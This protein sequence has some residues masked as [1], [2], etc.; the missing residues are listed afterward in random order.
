MRRFIVDTD[1]GSDDVWAVIEAL[2]AVDTVRV[3]A[4]TVVC[5]NFPL[6]L[7]VKNAMLAVEAAETYLPPVFRGRDEPLA[8]GEL[9]VADEVH[10]PDG[11][12]SMHL[13][14]S[15]RPVETGSAEDVI[16]DLVRKYPGEVE[17]V[18]CGPLTNLAAALQKDPAIAKMIRR[19]WILGGTYRAEG[20]LGHHVEYNVGTDPEAAAAVLASGMPAVWV[21]LDNARGDTEITPEETE[22][23][24][25]S[26]SRT[27]EFCA[28]CTRDL[29]AYYRRALGRDTYGVVDSCVMTAAI[30]PEIITESFEARC[31]VKLEAGEDRGR[32]LADRDA[33]E[34]NATVCARIDPVK[35][36]EKMFRLFGVK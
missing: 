2:R 5:G 36:K 23:L 15:T 30:Y 18:T 8:G 22:A 33:D 29:A 10:G 17:I 16:A 11:L 26:G 3:E 32:F 9:F 19:A 28:L 27:A 4:V 6:D 12:G 31:E 14:A 35:Y 7:C 1:T 21:V 24:L 20:N 13:P 34:P 25:N